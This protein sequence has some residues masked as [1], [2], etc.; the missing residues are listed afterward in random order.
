M[1]IMVNEIVIM[2]KT[3]DIFKDNCYVSF[4]CI[5]EDNTNNKLKKKRSFFIFTEYIFSR[6]IGMHFYYLIICCFHYLFFSCYYNYSSSFI[7]SLYAFSMPFTSVLLLLRL[8][9]LISFVLPPS[10]RPPS[11]S[12]SLSHLLSSPPNSAL[13]SR[14]LQQ[15]L[16]L[17]LNSSLKFL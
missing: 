17:F 5:F 16:P 10:S 3:H 14:P 11:Y 1:I 7:S 4:R 9:L 6:G 8:S 13:P 2:I 12:L 15:F